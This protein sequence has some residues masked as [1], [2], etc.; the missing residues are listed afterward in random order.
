MLMTH[1]YVQVLHAGAGAN[2]R[3]RSMHDAILVGI[4]TIAMDDP[5]LQSPFSIHLLNMMM[6]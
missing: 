6:S 5:R 4:N 1:W 2:D 3:L